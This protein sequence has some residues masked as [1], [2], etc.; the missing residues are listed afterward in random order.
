MRTRLLACVAGAL[1]GAALTSPI[2]GSLGLSPTVA[3]IACSLAG[4][5]V[6]NVASIMIHV[7]TASAE[8]E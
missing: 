8:T 3:L 7:F 1:I 5:A 4:I 2:N 6:G